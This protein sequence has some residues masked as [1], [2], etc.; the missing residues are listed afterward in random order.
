M[1]EV[2]FTDSEN[3]NDTVS[4]N[5][6]GPHNKKTNPKNVYTGGPTNPKNGGRNV[7]ENY[8][9]FTE[10]NKENKDALLDP[11]N[12]KAELKNENENGESKILDCK[13]KIFGWWACKP[14]LYYR[15]WRSN[16]HSTHHF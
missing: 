15:F 3:E 12:K 11:Q 4:E 1:K 13:P 5:K 6:T 9:V 14:E 7:N 2:I 10:N 8:A 16:P